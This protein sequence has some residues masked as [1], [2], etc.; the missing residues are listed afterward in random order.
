LAYLQSLNESWHYY[1][2]L[3]FNFYACWGTKA[4]FY[5]W[6][7]NSQKASEYA[8][9]VVEAQNSDGTSKFTLTKATDITPPGR[10]GLTFY[11]EQL[12]GIHNP[13]LQ[14]IVEP[15]FK[16]SAATTL[17]QT[18]LYMNSCYE[19]AINPED[20]RYKT[21]ANPTRYWEQETYSN[22][23]TINHFRKYTGNNMISS[24]NRVPLLRLSEMYLILIE[25]LP[26]AEATPLFSTYRI[27]RSMDISTEQ[28]S[29]T[30]EPARK[31]RVEKE[32]RKDF[33]GEGQMFYFYKR[34]NFNA[35]TWPANF[36]LPAN[37]Y[38]VPKPKDQIKFE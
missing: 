27:A 18:E 34:N 31:N 29:L 6:T 8:K 15:L 30:D 23:V 22:G 28:S 10:A 36:V 11:N 24:N 32:Y 14:R 2:Q 12:F 3:R 38:V 4:R 25:H 1:R 37:P 26:L 35:F 17:W 7:G 5:Q 21:T 9:K 19:S 33:F 20:I 13:D 16:N